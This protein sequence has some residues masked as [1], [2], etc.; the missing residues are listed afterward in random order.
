MSNSNKYDAIVIGS[1]IGGLT[2][3]AILSKYNHKKVLVLEQHYVIG[4]LT[5][6][7]ERKGFH[8]DVGIHYVGEMGEG[9]I[10]RKIFDY[11]TEG[12]LRWNKMP[13]PFE[14]FV[15]PDFTFEV[16]NEIARSSGLWGERHSLE[17][18]IAAIANETLLAIVLNLLN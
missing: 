4:G 5:H 12:K 15:Y 8:W 7:F 13:D 9:E 14:K 2:A 18:S 6:E 10:G 3:A 17:F 16:Y 1:G 11:I